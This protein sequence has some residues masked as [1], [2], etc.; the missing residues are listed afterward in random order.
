MTSR[1]RN[2][3]TFTSPCLKGERKASH[4]AAC[5]LDTAGRASELNALF[6]ERCVGQ[7]YSVP[8]PLPLPSPTRAASPPQ[9]SLFGS[10]KAQVRTPP[11]S[12]AE[13]RD[14]LKA[15]RRMLHDLTVVEP[16]ALLLAVHAACCAGQPGV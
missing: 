10:E 11:T 2:T 6:Q 1:G 15:A 3:P 13:E 12:D 16:L 9:T 7:Q 8:Q 14:G 4:S 5:S